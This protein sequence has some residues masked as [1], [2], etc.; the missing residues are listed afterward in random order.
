MSHNNNPTHDALVADWQDNAETHDDKNYHFLRSLK[1]KSEKKVDRTALDLH[2]EA[3][4]IVDCTKC[5]NCCR[6]LQ[7]SVAERGIKRI[8]GHLGMAREEFVAT[9]LERDEDEPGYRIKT[10]PCPFL[11]DDSK[12]TIY[13][14]KPEDCQ[15][16][17]FTNK[18]GF[19]FQVHHPRQ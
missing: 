2:Q 11:G 13:D 3:F 14:V 15:G 6:T 8:A 19:A 1:L 5:A 9:Y 17:P 7:P 10:T 4:N 18:R 12:C 16:Y